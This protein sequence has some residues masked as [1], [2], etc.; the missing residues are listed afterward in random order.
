[1]FKD[2]DSTVFVVRET[3]PAQPRFGKIRGW[4]RARD[5]AMGFSEQLRD[6]DPEVIEFNA[7]LDA[8]VKSNEE[9]PRREL[10]AKLS[11]LDAAIDT[12]PPEQQE[13]FKAVRDLLRPKP[14]A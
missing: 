13:A 6:A 5:D 3:D 1:M 11:A 9:R 8:V 14:T 7:H 12:L 10:E 4:Q 2:T